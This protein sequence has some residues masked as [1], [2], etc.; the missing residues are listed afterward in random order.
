VGAHF[1]GTFCHGALS[2]TCCPACV[3]PPFPAWVAQ[4][5]GVHS[6]RVSVSLEY[7]HLRNQR[8]RKMRQQLAALGHST[9]QQQTAS[10]LP[11]HMERQQQQPAVS[12]GS[13]WAG[14]A[15]SGTRQAAAPTA[16]P[17]AASLA[18]DGATAQHSSHATVAAQ[19]VQPSEGVPAST[20]A[21]AAAPPAAVG[22]EDWC[23]HPPGFQQQVLLT[24]QYMAF[25]HALRRFFD[26][27]VAVARCA[28]YAQF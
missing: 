5:Q 9:Q 16:G 4:I 11:Q 24:V 22:G 20:A 1:P 28:A 23:S 8:H 21:A 12:V 26:R 19:A 7:V 17:A 10:G 14:A 18:T 27:V 6:L 13:F 2:H 3:F 25:V 15:A